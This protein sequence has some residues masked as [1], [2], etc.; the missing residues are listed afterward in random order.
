M[1]VLRG[2]IA[3]I[4]VFGNVKI[5]FGSHNGKFQAKYA[6][7]SG[8]D[9]AIVADPGYDALSLVTVKAATLQEKTVTPS[10]MEQTVVPDVGILGLSKVIVKA[11]GD[12]GL[13][14]NKTV[15]PSDDPQ[16]VTPDEG[17]YGLSSVNVEAI[18][19]VSSVEISSDESFPNV[20]TFAIH[21]EDETVVSGS[22]AFDAAG[23]PTALTDDR[24]NMIEFSNGFQEAGV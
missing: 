4:R 20:N 1:I 12:H 24:G 7:P 13:L 22:V 10:S 23:L 16:T 17:Y 21:F 8:E 18:V 19:K 6:E 3:L 15:K 11:Q 2:R 5:A 9:Q 14:Q